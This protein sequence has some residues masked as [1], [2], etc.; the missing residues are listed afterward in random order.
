MN[1]FEKAVYYPYY[2][3]S[4]GFTES[5][6][7]L[8]LNSELR[9]EYYDYWKQVIVRSFQIKNS[10]IYPYC[11]EDSDKDSYLDFRIALICSLSKKDITANQ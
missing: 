10:L 8:V 6:L 2:G 4:C 1:D 11:F 5:Q 3:L 7:I 9:Q